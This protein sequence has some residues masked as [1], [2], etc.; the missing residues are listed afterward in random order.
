MKTIELTDREQTILYCLVRMEEINREQENW[1]M[2][3]KT[4]RF[5]DE[6]IAKYDRNSEVLLELSVLAEKLLRD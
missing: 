5:T 2:D 1:Q 3:K 4:E 6:E